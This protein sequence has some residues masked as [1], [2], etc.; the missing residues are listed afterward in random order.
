[1]NSKLQVICIGIKV[2]LDRGEE[3]E[4]ILTSYIKLTDIEKQTIREAFKLEVI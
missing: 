3:L 1:M 2:K 4:T